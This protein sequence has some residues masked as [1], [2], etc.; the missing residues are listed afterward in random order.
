MNVKPNESVTIDGDGLRYNQRS[1]VTLSADAL[2]A[3]HAA[4]LELERN[5]LRAQLGRMMRTAE[6]LT[7]ARERGNMTDFWRYVAEVEQYV[8]RDDDGGA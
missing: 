3:R 8:R 4:E 6:R 7:E 2:R 5:A 1:E